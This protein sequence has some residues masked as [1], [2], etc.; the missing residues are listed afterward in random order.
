MSQGEL[1]KISAKT[2]KEVAQR[3]SLGDEAFA[4][5]QDEMAP[6]Q[7]LAVLMEKGLHAD[8]ARFLAHALPKRE[9][10][11]WACHCAEQILGPEPP[12]AE[13]AA[14][15][16]ARTWVIDPSD[17][18]RRA[19]FTAAEAAKLGTPAGCAAMAAFMSGGSLAPPKL[20]VVPPAD[21][22]T[23]DFVAWSMAIGAVIKEPE[24][25]A[26]KYAG[27]LKF[28]LEV[29]EG[30]HLWAEAPAAQPTEKG[31]THGYARRPRR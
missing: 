19:A 4:L 2:A 12:P 29:A 21:H 13:A 1:T 23:A 11:W 20:T 8:A 5:H 25:A 3:F 7:F 30:Q 9:A 17:D 22:L 26:E 10:V 28:G 18:N 16:A 15:K 27:F 6:R 14:V 31:P 24:K